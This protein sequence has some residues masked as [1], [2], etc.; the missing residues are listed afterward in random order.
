MSTEARD[1]RIAQARGTLE[2]LRRIG[3]DLA[4]VAATRTAPI[5]TGELRGSME[6]AYLVNGA[7]FEGAGAFAAAMVE[8]IAAAAAG[9]L[10]TL[11]VEVSANTIYAA[12]QH[13]ELDWSHPLGGQAKYLEGPLVERAP[14]YSRIIDL[15][16]DAELLKVR[17]AR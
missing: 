4:G 3:E 12:R 7:R 1:L 13:E 9:V 10:R 15:A 6:V 5:E 16:Q 11:D 14:R 8:T 2:A 17:A